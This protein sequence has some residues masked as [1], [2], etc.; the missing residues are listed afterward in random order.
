MT[1]QATAVT[2]S[3]LHQAAQ[4]YARQGWPVFPCEASGKRP[5]TAHGLKDASTELAAVDAWWTSQ[6]EANIG[7]AAG[8]ALGKFVLDVDGP[9]GDASLAALEKKHGPLPATLEQKTGR[10][11]HLFFA[12]PAEGDVRNSAGQLGQGLDIRGTGGYVVV[13]P[14][15]HPSGDSY[16]WAEGRS[17]DKIQPAEAPPWLIEAVQHKP[18][19][20]PVPRPEWRG[21]GGNRAYAEAALED[22]AAKVAQA[23]EGQRNAALNVAAHSLGQLVGAGELDQG[24]VE[25]ELTRAAVHAGLGAVETQHTIKSGLHAGMQKPREVPASGHHGV[26][27]HHQHHERGCEHHHDTT[28]APRP[29]R[30]QMP[31]PEPY[32]VDALVGNLAAAVRGIH[33]RVQSPIAICAQSVLAV[34]TLAVQ[35][36]ANV[37]INGRERPLNGYYI[38]IAESG[39]RKTSTDDE[40][41]WAIHKREKSLRERYEVEQEQ[42]RDEHA[43]WDRQRQQILGDKKAYPDRETKRAALASLGNEPE[44]PL[45][46]MLTADEPTYEGLVRLL[47]EGQ[48]S[49]GVFSN[50]G[51]RFVGGHAMNA[52]NRLKTSAALSE[53]WDGKP[54]RRVR[55]GDGAFTLYGRRVSLHLMMQ[56]GVAATLLSDD[57][58]RDQGI[59]TR[60]LV[61]YPETT[62]G[63]RFQR[64]P[65]AESNA[66]VKAYHGRLMRILETPLP[67][68]EDKRNELLPRA[69]PLSPPAQQVW[70]EFADHIEG[71]LGPG[72]DLEPIRG[73]ASKIAEHAARLAG[74][75][76]LFENLDAPD[77]SG[78]AMAGAINLAQFYTTEMLRLEAAGMSDPELVLAE[79]LLSWLRDHW[80]E[81]VIALVDIYQSG[82]AAIR[83]TKTARKIVRILEAHGWL[84]PVPGGATVN[85]TKRRE[86]WRIIEGSG[87]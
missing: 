83:D 72:G 80:K 17:P 33:D 2:L 59:L 70:R 85:G 46:P 68:V 58:L 31:P 13:A 21:G 22:E 39:E 11:R 24:E 55:Q 52:D 67:M 86:V 37:V 47:K 9:E 36:F 27:Q 23:P 41:A 16:R 60:L 76:T 64:E 19:P 35:G 34:A 62:A 65:S 43:A 45:L 3:R 15:V 54:I 66:A 18:P 87:P 30:R 32:P 71:R 49:I 4:W 53:L 40:A 77:V 63:T 8:A 69:L 28:E 81:P 10:G 42:Y 44:A 5:M 74:V 1:G 82:P 20:A 14:S 48:P 6:S 57:M 38:D 61:A 50:E 7:V 73:F 51:G 79:R 56:P 75:M 12:M 78:E 29:L 26:D 25:A 84:V